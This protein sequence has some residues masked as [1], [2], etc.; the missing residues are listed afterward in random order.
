MKLAIFLGIALGMVI[1][2]I[3]IIIAPILY[4]IS[5]KK[6]I[7]K[8]NDEEKIKKLRVLKI[9]TLVWVIIII[10]IIL[11]I[12][13]FFMEQM[14]KGIDK[15]L[16]Y[17]Y[18]EKEEVVTIE[19]GKPQNLTCTYPKY[20]NTWKVLANPNGNL[21]D[22][23]TNRNLYGLYWE[24]KETTKSKMNEGFC[25]KAEDT[26]SFLEEKLNIL[27][28]TEREANEFIIYWLPKLEKNEYNL[29]RFQTMEEINDNMPL[30]ISPKPDTLI[31]IVMEYKPLKKYINIKEQQ[32]FN[33][34]RM[35][36]TVVE[37]G[38]TEIK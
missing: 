30:E 14:D 25:V 38:G 28:L 22:L 2:T 37:W 12:L 32:L 19:L 21:V 36:F 5:T 13:S 3:I 20:E 8:Y 26:I 1:V 11:F 9:K 6:T 18:P 10:A 17:L 29:I 15:P 7:E 24:G 34:E 35:G 31:R 16:I 27:G 33:T 4:Y 23:N